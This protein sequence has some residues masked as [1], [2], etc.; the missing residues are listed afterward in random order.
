[1]DPNSLRTMGAAAGAAGD[2]DPVYLSDVFK[3]HL[4]DGTGSA[5]SIVNGID[6]AGEG[7]LV[8]IKNRT[9]SGQHVIMDTERGAGHKLHTDSDATGESGRT[10]LL[11][12][13]NSNGFSI[14]GSD[15]YSNSSSKRYVS[16]TFRKQKKFFDIVTYTGT[17]ANRTIP[18]NLGSVPGMII[19]KQY[20]ATGDWYVYHR[21]S[22]ADPGDRTLY[23][24][25]VNEAQS[26]PTAYNGTQPTASVFSVGTLGDTNGLNDTFVAYLF[27]H[28]DGD[29]T[30]GEDQ[31]QDIIKCGSY[32]G[33]GS[34]LKVTLGFEPQFLIVKSSTL[35]NDDWKIYDSMRGMSNGNDQEKLFSNGDNEEVSSDDFFEVENDGFR[36][37][38]NNAA[39]NTNTEKYIYIAIAANTG[40]NGVVPT[41]ASQVFAM[42]TGNN[43]GTL[44]NFDSNFPVDFVALK[45]PAASGSWY[46]TARNSS[47]AFVISDGEAAEAAGTDR[48]FDSM[49]GWAVGS[50]YASHW[51]SWMWKRQKSFFDI[52]HYQGTGSA[53]TLNHGLGSVP[54]FI[55]YKN[56]D[57]TDLWTI[58]HASANSGSSPEDYFYQWGV[59]DADVTQGATSDGSGV[60][61]NSAA[62]TSTT[63]SV[64]TSNATNKSG[65]RMVAFLFGELATISKFGEYTGTGSNTADDYVN[66][67]FQPRFLL[68]KRSDAASDWW[69]IDSLRGMGT[70]NDKILD[71]TLPASQATTTDFITI[72]SSGFGLQAA[73]F[74]QS[75]GKY[76]YYAIA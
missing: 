71:P 34:E 16:W 15:N 43:D 69:W 33:T 6:L 62:P 66:V 61:F 25:T 10:D 7:G 12:A 28:H 42:D 30:F 74:N 70:G 2:T 50:G 53:R 44:P 68:I 11:S 4:Y 13:F 22:H 27:A 65:S 60:R 72:S 52:V 8:W 73:Y 58:Y 32:T 56:Y 75:S 37:I 47:E 76:I 29:G 46:L 24:N 51:Q 55:L 67:G 26:S 63:I 59:Y 39:F 54:K 21:N 18:H 45:K 36:I 35:T 31:D 23:L 40:L 41:A 19:I 48:T 5:T 17:G 1:M 57:T 49:V 14:G 9:S 3:T 38:T 20:N 64:G